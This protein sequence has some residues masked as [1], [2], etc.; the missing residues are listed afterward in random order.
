LQARRWATREIP[1]FN[2]ARCGKETERTVQRSGPKKKVN[3]KQTYCSKKCSATGRPAGRVSAGF[4]HRGNGYRYIMIRGKIIAEHRIVMEREL[5]RELTKR[6]TVH[7]KNG[8][9]SDNRPE[10]LELWSHNHGPGARVSDL[11]F[12]DLAAMP[13][14]LAGALSFGA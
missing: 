2:C 14:V 5:G 4:V 12:H 13:G 7:H 10:N 1:K 11:A 3:W 9:R 8:I 6:E